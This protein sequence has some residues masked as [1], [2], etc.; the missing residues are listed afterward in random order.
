MLREIFPK[1]VMDTDANLIVETVGLTIYQDGFSGLSSFTKVV[2][3]LKTKK[4]SIDL[5]LYVFDRERIKDQY[6]ENIGLINRLLLNVPIIGVKTGN[7]GDSD[8]QNKTEEDQQMLKAM[9]KHFTPG[10]L[11]GVV[12]GCFKKP[13]M[14]T[15]AEQFKALRTISGNELKTKIRE[16]KNK[17][18]GDESRDFTRFHAI[19]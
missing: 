3:A 1:C 15:L 16:F 18:K 9:Q 12:S 10:Q 14:S 4:I 19:M 5:I 8:G 6:Y 11:I 7:D 13:D 17:L 2:T